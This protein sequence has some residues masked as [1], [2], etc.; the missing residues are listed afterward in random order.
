MTEANVERVTIS[1]NFRVVIP[2]SLRR[3]LGLEPGQ[4]VLV[5]QDGRSIRM[6]PHRPIAEYW[7]IFRGIELDFEREDDRIF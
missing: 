6:T 3:A 4:K 7:G 5:V 2:L 1:S